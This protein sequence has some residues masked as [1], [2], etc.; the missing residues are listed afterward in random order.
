MTNPPRLPAVAA[1]PPN[2]SGYG[3]YL[4]L[5]KDL[6]QG[7]GGE[8]LSVVLQDATGQLA[9]RV[10]DNVAHAS[11]EFDAGEFVKALGRTQ[12]HQGRLQLVVERIR[13]VMDGDTRDG[14]RE[15]D[16]TER[17]PRPVE[18]MWQELERL[19]GAVENPHLRELLARVVAE[20][21]ARLR[22]WPAAMSVHHAYRG[23]F[24][25]HVLKVAETARALARAYGADVDV[26]TAGAL[27]HDIGKLRELEFE[28]TVTYTRD[29]NLLGHITI[30]VMLVRE[31]ARAIAGFPDA[32]RTHVEHVVL[33]HHGERELGSPVVPMTAEAFIVATADDL[34][35]R[36][37]QVRRALASDAG[38]GEFTPYLPRLERKLWKGRRPTSPDA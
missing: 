37:H 34:D 22:V 33:S 38:D 3:F 7:R 6:R 19:V 32:L 9:A 26:V 24:L 16:C 18:E 10:F 29:G 30:G 25:E 11:E 31:A 8:Y 36:L 1:L 35:A 21:E 28:T 20:H 17:A 13:R 12:I 23:G 15:E 4:C 5:S 2:A 14:F 27:L